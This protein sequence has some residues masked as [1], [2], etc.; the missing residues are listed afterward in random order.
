MF[1][2]SDLNQNIA[3]LLMV[4]YF[5]YIPGVSKKIQYKKDNTIIYK[6][7]MI[8]AIVAATCLVFSFVNNPQLLKVV[9]ILG[10]CILA[11]EV[12][13]YKSEYANY[14]KIQLIFSMVINLILTVYTFMVMQV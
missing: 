1:I 8:M 7:Q 10:W 4:V 12:V 11:T 14:Y 9:A 3:F 6:I 13:T 5:I 2:G